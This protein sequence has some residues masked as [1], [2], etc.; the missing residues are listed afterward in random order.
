MSRNKL[1]VTNYDFQPPRWMSNKH[2]QTAIGTVTKHRF[3]PFPYEKWEVPIEDGHMLRGKLWRNEKS[4]ALAIL[5]HGLGGHPDSHYVLGAA[6]ELRKHNMNVLRMAMRGAEEHGFDVSKGIYH[7][8]LT[9]DLDSNI[10]AAIEKGYGPIYLVGYSLSANMILKWMAQEKKP[11]EKAFVVSPPVRLHRAA[12]LLDHWKN[13]GYQLYFLKKMKRMIVQKA[14]AFPNLY[15]QYVRDE[16]F[17]SVQAYDEYITSQIFGF[18]NGKDYYEFSSS[19]PVLDQ[20]KNQV[21]IV[22]SKDDPFLECNDL[23]LFSK[24]AQSNVKVNLYNKGGHMGF[25]AGNG[26][27]KLW[28]W[29]G[30]YFFEL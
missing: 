25:Y 29:P 8:G 2:I 23:E 27:Y 16:F 19:Y 12:A 13:K 20:I 22:H 15:Q 9:Q 6:G 24:T 10:Q 1:S 30:V 26:Q 17:K 5:Y 3:S 7:G 18:K 4:K 14:D 21:M 28:H 11:V